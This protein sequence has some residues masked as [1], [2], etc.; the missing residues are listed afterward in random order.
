[1]RNIEGIDAH[2]AYLKKIALSAL[3]VLRENGICTVG[4]HDEKNGATLTSLLPKQFKTVL[5][6]GIIP[7]IFSRMQR[8]QQNTTELITGAD[9]VY[10]L[11]FSSAQNDA[12]AKNLMAPFQAQFLEGYLAFCHS[13]PESLPL[14]MSIIHEKL[15]FYYREQKDSVR[16]T[17]HLNDAFNLCLTHWKETEEWIRLVTIVCN[18]HIFRSNAEDIQKIELLLNKIKQSGVQRFDSKALLKSFYWRIKH[19]ISCDQKQGPP[20]PQSLTARINA[21]FEKA[22]KYM[23]EYGKPLPTHAADLKFIATHKCVVARLLE[24]E[25]INF[26]EIQKKLF[27]IALFSEKY[28]SHFI[29]FL[30]QKN[31]L[32][33]ALECNAQV[34]S[35]DHHEKKIVALNCM[36]GI[37]MSAIECAHSFSPKETGLLKKE[38]FSYVLLLDQACE[39]DAEPLCRILAIKKICS[40]YFFLYVY[41]QKNSHFLDRIFAL[42]A[43]ASR[44]LVRNNRDPDIYNTMETILKIENS[45]KRIYTIPEQGWEA[46]CKIEINRLAAEI[47]KKPIPPESYD[48]KAE[49]GDKQGMMNEKIKEDLIAQENALAKIK[50]R[51]KT[52][53]QQ[54]KKQEKRIEFLQTEINGLRTQQEKE[55]KEGLLSTR[56]R[57]EQEKEKALERELL[58]LTKEPDLPE[59]DLDEKIALARKQKSEEEKSQHL[60]LKLEETQNRFF[61]YTQKMPSLIHQK[62]VHQKN[63]CALREEKDGILRELTREQY[64]RQIRHTQEM[65]MWDFPEILQEAEEEYA[66]RY[67]QSAL[68]QSGPA[69]SQA[70][71]QYLFTVAAL[72][73]PQPFLIIYPCY[74][75]PIF[76]PPVAFYSAPYPYFFSYARQ[77]DQPM[78]PQTLTPF[79]YSQI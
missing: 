18:Q 68:L 23:R 13:L 65:E 62:E 19:L 29:L 57:E 1:M 50:K 78:P 48:S 74:Y 75:I 44:I 22:E 37:Y 70:W 4:A 56:L 26:D 5:E 30:L 24:R 15:S 11:V 69:S 10:F 67:N 40:A 28:L 2:I 51:L 14:N 53:A 8:E 54:A 46:F 49:V 58:E 59:K 71:Q 77:P 72:Y 73:S 36:L 16:H 34:S 12:T 55:Q 41:Y 27:S 43:T 42:S 47:E 17:R 45:A 6:E 38:F 21:S 33:T 60:T 52:L 76:S 35:A 20:P 63:I 64:L 31:L 9:N 32:T 39:H 3:A 7:G 25:P 61:H 66:S 79:S